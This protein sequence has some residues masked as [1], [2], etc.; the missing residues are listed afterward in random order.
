MN[1]IAK[2]QFVKN[3]NK[4]SYLYHTSKTEFVSGTN[5]QYSSIDLKVNRVRCYKYICLPPYCKVG[6]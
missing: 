3:T 5:A 2:T 4:L 6:F 1:V